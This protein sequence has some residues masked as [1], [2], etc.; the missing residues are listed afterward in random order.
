MKNVQEIKPCYMETQSLGRRGDM[1]LGAG[2][3][4]RRRDNE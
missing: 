2:R 3:V 4:V 1:A